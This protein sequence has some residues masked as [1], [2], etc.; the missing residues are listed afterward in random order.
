MA[1]KMTTGESEKER[2]RLRASE[3]ESDVAREGRIKDLRAS[4]QTHETVLIGKRE[5]ERAGSPVSPGRL[6]ALNSYYIIHTRR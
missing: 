3:W 6:D 1:F 4:P 2:G 5:R